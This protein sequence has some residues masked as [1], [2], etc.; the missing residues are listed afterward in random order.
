MFGVVAVKRSTRC[1]PGVTPPSTTAH[2]LASSSRMIQ[3]RD[4]FFASTVRSGTP[5][6]SGM[7]PDDANAGAATGSGVGSVAQPPAPAR[8]APAAANTRYD[9]IDQV[10]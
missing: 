8:R 3:E 2:W 10:L 5:S 4:S 1:T 6:R 7:P 9:R